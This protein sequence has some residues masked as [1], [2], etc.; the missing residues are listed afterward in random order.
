MPEPRACLGTGSVTDNATLLF[1]RTNN[2][3]VANLI[4]GTGSLIQSGTGTTTLTAANTYS[5]PT[6][7]SA[8]TLKDGIA[9]ALPTGTTLTV[10]GTGIFDLGGFA[11]TV[12]GL[13]DGGVNTST[14]T[15]SGATATFTVN[16]AAPIAS[17][18][19]SQAHWL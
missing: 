12:A 5:G 13:A 9:N 6:T 14:V 18:A 17:P 15:D 4:S 3:T 19:P 8:G 11:Q 1:N 7:V 10:S 2:F 16:D